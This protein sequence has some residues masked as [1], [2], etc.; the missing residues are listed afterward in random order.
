MARS[1]I[2]PKKQDN[3]MSR[4]SGDWRRQGRGDVGGAGGGVLTKPEKGGVD[5][6]GG[7]HE[8]VGLGPLCQL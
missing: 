1:P 7:L 6:I 5:N 2:Q 8:I 4:R 3:R